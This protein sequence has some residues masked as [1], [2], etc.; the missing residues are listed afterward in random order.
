M[1]TAN[2]QTYGCFGNGEM[3]KLNRS[4]DLNKVPQW[5]KFEDVEELLNTSTNTNSKSMPLCDCGKVADYP[6]CEACYDRDISD[7]EYRGA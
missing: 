1:D 5:V 6:I 7:A 3:Y 2:L 4:A